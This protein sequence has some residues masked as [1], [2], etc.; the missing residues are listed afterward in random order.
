M[1]NGLTGRWVAASVVAIAIAM[2]PLASS[3]ITHVAKPPNGASAKL[4][5][6]LKDMNGHSVQL[7]SFKGHP[8]L[9][10]FW[11]TWCGPCREEIP[12][13]VELME[14][15]RHKGFTV[16]GIS[17]DDTAEELRPFVAEYK[18]NY[19][20]LIGRDQDELL[21]TYEASLGVPISWFIRADGTI[22]LK[23]AGYNTKD[24]FDR[25]IQALF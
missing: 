8:M 7:A 14:K 12:Q 21:D 25:Q 5:Y 9:L 20:V 3:R 6:T 16:V 17:T 10:N 4:D 11:A 24:W 23:H 22:A 15:Y 13:L 18:M 2:W 19:P 1:R